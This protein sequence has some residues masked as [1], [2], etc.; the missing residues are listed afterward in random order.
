M[1][2]V[3]PGGMVIFTGA[4]WVKLRQLVGGGVVSAETSINV[5]KDPLIGTL[6]L[7]VR[8]T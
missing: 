2:T 4:C 3:V 6:Q 7:L 5:W 8:S 1:K